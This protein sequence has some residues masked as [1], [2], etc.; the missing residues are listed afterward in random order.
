V[1]F[2]ASLTVRLVHD[3]IQILFALNETYYAG[4]GNNLVFVE[5]F[6][7]V[8]VGFVER[9][10]TVLYP[11]TGDGALEEQYRQ[12]CALIDETVAL[13]QDLGQA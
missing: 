8:P 11:G 4:D 10:H 12:V 1:V 13:V 2:L 7:H 9:V 3:L 6:E 5:H